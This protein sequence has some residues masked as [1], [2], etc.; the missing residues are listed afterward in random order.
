MDFEN[1]ENTA[2]AGIKAFRD[3]LV[4]IGMPQTF[5]EIGAKEEDIEKM[6]HRAAFGDGAGGTLGGFVSLDQ[7]D[8]EKIYRM[9]L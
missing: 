2:K 9:M 3:Y 5:A 1:P 7:S 4:S 8:I 6:A